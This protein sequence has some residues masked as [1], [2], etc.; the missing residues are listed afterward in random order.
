MRAAIISDP[1]RAA[2]LFTPTSSLSSFGSIGL[3]QT[4][5]DPGSSGDRDTKLSEAIFTK[6]S[7]SYPTERRW[8]GATFSKWGGE[9]YSTLVL[10]VL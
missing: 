2:A 4:D 7:C 5:R 10:G 8:T 1:S 6:N 3:P 9:S